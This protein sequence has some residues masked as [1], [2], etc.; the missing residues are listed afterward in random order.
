MKYASRALVG[1]VCFFCTLTALADDTFDS[2]LSFLIHSE[3]VTL[4]PTGLHRIDLKTKFEKVSGIKVI[5]GLNQGGVPSELE[6]IVNGNEKEKHTLAIGEDSTEH[7]IPVKGQVDTIEFK[8]KKGKDIVVY[9]VLLVVT[10]ITDLVCDEDCIALVKLELPPHNQGVFLGHQL[11]RLYNLTR[12]RVNQREQLPRVA[13]VVETAETLV[14]VARREKDLSAKTIDALFQVYLAMNDAD[15]IFWSLAG[16]PNSKYI[17]LR[18]LAIENEI[19]NRLSPEHKS[20][21]KKSEK[22]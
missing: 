12:N 21:V 6:V 19:G 22:K 14:R 8:H 17:G 1:L 4:A 5:A 11:I 3:K 13:A 18:Y 7:L 16:T 15:D 20:R 10:E 9:E 2:H